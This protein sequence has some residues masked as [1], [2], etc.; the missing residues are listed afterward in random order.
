MARSRRYLEPNTACYLCSQ[1]IE[2][3]QNWNR[4]HIP[5]HAG[6]WGCPRLPRAV[7]AEVVRDNRLDDAGVSAP[8][9]GNGELN[10]QDLGKDGWQS[11]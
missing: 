1:A 8:A 7:F 4:D 11:T 6:S 2:E 5:R 10:R 3:G 9:I